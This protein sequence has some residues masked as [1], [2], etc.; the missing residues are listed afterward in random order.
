MARMGS[1]NRLWMSARFSLS[2]VVTAR[3]AGRRPLL[4]LAGLEIGHALVEPRPEHPISP[5]MGRIIDES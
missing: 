2:T 5:L 3:Q 4:H 1:P